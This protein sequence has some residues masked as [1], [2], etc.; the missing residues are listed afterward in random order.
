[1]LGVDN[2]PEADEPLEGLLAKLADEGLD[3]DCV[4]AETSSDDSLDGDDAVDPLD[5]DQPSEDGL[6]DKLLR[7]DADDPL[8]AETSSEDVDDSGAE[9]LL[10]VEGLDGD[11]SDDAE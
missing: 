11:D 1:M 10:S 4:E 9:T 7:E 5:A 6:L 8:L 3:T 2:S